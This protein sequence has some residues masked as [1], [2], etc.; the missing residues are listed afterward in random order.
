MQ[1]AVE[2]VLIVVVYLIIVVTL[3]LPSVALVTVAVAAEVVGLVIFS[4]RLFGVG[5]VRGRRMTDKFCL[6]TSTKNRLI[7]RFINRQ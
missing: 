1:F 6:Q 4:C 3:V 5:I 7:H 2:A